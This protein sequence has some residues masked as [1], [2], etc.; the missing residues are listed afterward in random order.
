MRRRRL[1]QLGSAGLASGLAGCNALGGT[2]RATPTETDTPTGTPTETG[3]PTP[4]EEPP[5]VEPLDFMDL[6]P[7]THLKGT[8]RTEN[9]NFVRIDWEWY[10][11]HYEMP[12][13]FGAASNEDWTLAVNDGNFSTPPPKYRLLHTPVGTT[14]Q[15][16][17]LVANLLPQFPNLGPELVRQCGFEMVNEAGQDDSRAHHVGAE[18]ATIDQVL[19]YAAPGMTY[20]IGV[21]IDGLEAA[22]ADNDRITID[23]HPNSFLYAG[24]G[25]MDGRG[26]FL[27]TDWNRPVLCVETGNEDDRAINRP[28]ARLTDTGET[29]S[30]TTLE[31]VR[32]CLSQFVTDVP[33]VVGQ[34]NGGRARFPSSTYV[35]SPIR[36]LEGYDTV[37]NGMTI[38][39]G[40]SATSQVVIS[41]VDGK[42]PT[43]AELRELYGPEDGEV[44]TDFHPSVSQLSASW[45]S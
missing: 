41:L 31:S 43:D 27:S 28:I 29:L 25:R 1:L 24:S 44:S 37:M 12:M 34:I 4:R 39:T 33:V 6:L 22:L 18:S 40:S 9:A 38:Q 20:F 19:S 2:D 26:M 15:M 32:W 21:D 13:R 8:E 16:G 36:S 11:Q 30:V 3:T 45:G 10:L 17:G 14:L 23:N 35:Q 5:A 42:A 7:A